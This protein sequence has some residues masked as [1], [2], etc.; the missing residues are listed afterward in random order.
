[1]GNNPS[2]LS[3]QCMSTDNQCDLRTIFHG[4]VPTHLAKQVVRKLRTFLERNIRNLYEVDQQILRQILFKDLHLRYDWIYEKIKSFG[5]KKSLKSIADTVANAIVYK[6]PPICDWLHHMVHRK[7]ILDDASWLHKC[8]ISWT[9]DGE[10]SYSRKK[11]RLDTFFRLLLHT[12]V[13]FEFIGKEMSDNKSFRDFMLRRYDQCIVPNNSI[14]MAWSPTRV[15]SSS[16]RKVYHLV[17]QL[18][19][20]NSLSEREELSDKVRFALTLNIV[21]ATLYDYWVLNNKKRASIG[22]GLAT[23]PIGKTR[24]DKY[25]KEYRIQESAEFVSMYLCWN[26]SFVMQLHNPHLMIAK[27]LHPYVSNAESEVF[28]YRRIHSLFVTMNANLETDALRSIHLGPLPHQSFWLD[29][30]VDILHDYA[31]QY[32]SNTHDGKELGRHIIRDNIADVP[33]FFSNLRAFL[34]IR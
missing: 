7:K 2:E 28:M 29:P 18:K 16:V 1:M 32:Y 22:Y 14:L 11:M 8:K 10:I 13:V 19:R 27:L 17:E 26:L 25:T 3:N 31:K 23:T 24:Y 20:E 9:R 33:S 34:S 6:Y 15:K 5:N 21:E 12:M 30:F 4:S